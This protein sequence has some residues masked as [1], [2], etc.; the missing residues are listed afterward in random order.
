MQLIIQ[1]AIKFVLVGILNTGIDFGVLNILMRV[2]GI[3]SGSGY[4]FFKGISFVAAVINSYFLNKLWTFKGTGSG[5]TQ[6]EFVQFL[7]VSVIGFGVNVGVASFVVNVISPRF[8]YSGVS[9]VI[10]ANIGAVVATACS[11]VWNFIGYKFIV[12]KNAKPGSLP[13]IQA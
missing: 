11:M 3:S 4:T 2:S 13:K 10:W 1:Q 5:K 7:I 6:K 9:E 12:F 8:P